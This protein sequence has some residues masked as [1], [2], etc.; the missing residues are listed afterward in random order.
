G[1][2]GGGAG[3]GYAQV[4]PM[5]DIN[6]LFTGDMP[7]IT[8][9]HN[10]LAALMDNHLYRGNKLGLKLGR[11]TWKRV[12]DQ[13]ERSLRN[14]VIGLG[15]LGGVPR[16]SGFEITSA[17]E[18]TAILALSTSI[19]ELKERLGRI[20]VG[21][22]LKYVPITAEQLKARGVMALLLK[23]AI[24]PNLVQTLENNPA[25]V[26]GGPFANI[27]HGCPSLIGIKT[28]LKLADYVVV[29]PGFGSDLGA[30]KFMDVAARLG[31]LNPS[32]VVIVATLKAL[33]YH[34]GVKI[35]DVGEPN[36]EA[37]KKGLANLGA[38]IDNIS[39]F[40]VPAVVALNFFP[41]DT[42][43]EI[44][45]VREFCNEYNTPF[46]VSKVFLEGG[47]G[48]QELARIVLNTI[49]NKPAHYKPLY[50]LDM[51][52]EE[53][54]ETIAKKVYGADGVNYTDTARTKLKRIVKRGKTDLLIMM[55]KTQ[56]SLS[57][58]P[59][60]LGRPSNFKIT[61]T[62]IR[63]ATGAGFLVAYCGDIRT[64]P[65]LPS[66]PAAERMDIDEDGTITGLF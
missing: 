9:S 40:G 34:G 21:Y 36:L 63:E 4:Q 28:S 17:S 5:Y 43:E 61:V 15:S 51:S 53:R 25:I 47:K 1:V 2:K 20:T 52:Y 64:L 50:T 32:V 56:Y 11:I 48:G 59:K 26:H 58:D 33:R 38:H 30:E 22:G 7:A 39:N 35:S 13:D 16:E 18:V 27:A 45:A 60:K 37:V 62:D 54:I 10:V 31:N 49:E 14:I 55:A 66:K 42:D 8:A 57:D 41:T 12:L 6:L 24:M 23:D 46:A 44:K 65:A 29:E 3:G 19:T